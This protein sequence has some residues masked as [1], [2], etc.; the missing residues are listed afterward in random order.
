M[1]L[2]WGQ[3]SVDIVNF[4]PDGKSS[5]GNPSRKL[6]RKCGTRQDWLFM[7]ETV[8]SWQRL[9]PR[10]LT[11]WSYSPLPS[12]GVAVWCSEIS[13]H[14]CVTK[15][16]QKVSLVSYS[17]A[18]DSGTVIRLCWCQAPL[19]NV[20]PDGYDLFLVGFVFLSHLQ[21]PHNITQNLSC[22][23]TFP[24]KSS[25][26]LS[27]FSLKLWP[28]KAEFQLV[29][30]AQKA[31]LFLIVL[32]ATKMILKKKKERDAPLLNETCLPLFVTAP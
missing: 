7:T 19:P 2:D 21:S 16:P 1:Y 24:V 13:A 27:F 12:W 23:R 14:L 28:L 26:Y 3:T 10:I 32:W 17:I 18:P 31:L 6:H 4:L 15:D 9:S 20:L 29:S 22:N 8:P 30:D 11:W 5:S 25:S